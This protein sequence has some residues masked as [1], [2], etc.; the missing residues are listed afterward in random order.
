MADVFEKLQ[1]LALKQ[2]GTDAPTTQS[3]LRVAV[4]LAEAANK[5][6]GL[7]GR[8]KLD[9]VLKTL[10]D[11]LDMPEVA[12]RIPVDARGPL[13]IVVDTVVPE[14]LSLIIEAGRG[15]YDLK[16]PSV[17][18]LAM[19]C[20]LTCRRAGARVGGNVGVALTAVAVKVEEVGGVPVDATVPVPVAESPPPAPVEPPQ[21]DPI[22]VV[23]KK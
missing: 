23:E 10:R 11:V 21:I 14:A 4:V 1:Q 16:K 2:F 6:K 12:A 19:L 7:N 20:G 15:Q 22:S 9:L 13:K 18:C 8:A 3:V 17:G 5:I